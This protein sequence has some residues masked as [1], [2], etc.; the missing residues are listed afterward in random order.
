[1]TSFFVDRLYQ[2]T[3]LDHYL[4]ERLIVYSRSEI[5]AAI[6]AGKVHVNDKRVT[7]HFQLRFKDKILFDEST[8]V[9][10]EHKP[11]HERPPRAFKPQ[12]APRV[13]A[14][15][16]QYFILDKPAGW[17][18][19]ASDGKD[20]A[21]LITDF[22]LDL[23][24]AIAVVGDSPD[25]R[26]GIVHRLDREVSGIVVI[27]RTQQFFDHIKQQ[28]INKTVR[29]TYQALVFGSPAK[30]EET[31]SFRIARS[32]RKAR[33][34]ALPAHQSD[35]KDATTHFVVKERFQHT[36]HLEVWVET[37]RTNQIRVH[38]AAYNIP[39]VGDVMYGQRTPANESVGRVMLHADYITFYDLGGSKVE[40]RSE[41]PKE[42]TALLE[43]GRKTKAKG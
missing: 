18:M 8:P 7:P 16:N 5:Q 26:P 28:F 25:I 17:L 33:M 6:A 40:Y 39:I 35:G 31:I 1:M 3:R 2:G 41:L 12:Q 37:G 20:R 30:D 11:L 9:R 32:R 43:R 34:A 38:L 4:V 13:I 42:F 14:E 15:T 36:T 23:D 21:P 29:K 24:P 10:K 19:H 22:I 27:P